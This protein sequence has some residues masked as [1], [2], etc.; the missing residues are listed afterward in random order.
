MV[1]WFENGKKMRKYLNTKDA[2]DRWVREQKKYNDLG[3]SPT[4]MYAS[5]RL[6]HGTGFDMEMVLKA[7]LEQLR[8]LGAHRAD[9]TMTFR[10]AAQAV[11]ER[12]KE[13]GCRAKTLEN[14]E[15][16]AALLNKKWGDRVAVGISTQE[17]KDHLAG[18]ANAKG[19]PGTAARA[20]KETHL[21]YLRMIQ[22]TAGVVMPLK[23]ILLP[24][25]DRQVQY[26]SIEEVKTMLA[27]C[28]VDARGYLAVALFGCVR[29][30]N[31][32]LLPADCVSASAKTIRI[33]NTVSKDRLTHVI[34]DK[35]PVVLWEWLKAYPFKPVHREPLQR[36]LKRAIGRWIH[37]GLRHTGA[38][39]YCAVHGV[40]A[41]AQLLTHES[42]SLVRKHYAGVV[43]DPAV[44]ASFYEL[45]PAKI[46][47]S[48]PKGVQWPEKA[49]LKTMLKTRT[50]KD[51]AEELGC[52]DVALSKHCERV[53]ILR[54][55]RG[56]WRV[57]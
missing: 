38:T 18:L 3:I 34:T 19:V 27:V 21:L 6:I 20:T 41:T 32:E 37:D 44:P 10:E 51:V 14:Y 35:A 56:D 55:G 47:F 40:N 7:G 15:A 11:I 17:V 54:P 2:A 4:E 31:L 46:S 13:K 5:S 45:S 52:S 30:D 28:P 57:S 26:F 16:M 49:D 23:T 1:R 8:G 43:L 29:P 53:G 48:P 50:G 22:R 42:E 12:A 36:R 24:K 39:Y 33:P 9:A 25:E